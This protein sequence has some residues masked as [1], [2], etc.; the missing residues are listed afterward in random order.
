M[1]IGRLVIAVLLLLLLALAP[2]MA[3]TVVYTGQT[4]PLAVEQKN[5]DVYK[6]ELYNDGT[7]DFATEPGNC[8]ASLA[9][10]DPVGGNIGASVNVKWVEPGI[11]FFKVTALNASGCAMN[12]KIGIIEV[13]SSA[14]A[15]I[16]QPTGPVCAGEPV[17]LEIK[18]SGT[19]P[20]DF[21]YTA[22]DVDDVTTTH[23][24]ED[25]GTD[26]YT[27]TIV[28]GPI[29]TT[30]YTIIS[31]TDQNGTN[32]DPSNTVTQVVKALPVPVISGLAT[33][34]ANEEGV[35]Y[36]TPE[37]AGNTY[38]WIVT[39][40]TIT[41]GDETHEI[42]VTWDTPG[43]GTVEV[44]ET[45]AVTSCEKTV[46]ITVDVKQ[47]P[48]PVIAGKLTACEDE[49]NV[50]YST[51]E[52][53][54]NTYAWVVTGGTITAGDETHEITV[55]WD[56]PGNG[57][58]E[59]TETMAVTSCEKTV[60]ITVD[61]KQ[62]P[63]PVIA[64]KL[65]ACEDEENVVY[66]T[67]EVAGNTYAWVVTGGSITDGAGTHE[68]TVTW[69]TIGTGSVQVTETMAVTNCEKTVSITVPVNAIPTT[70]KILHD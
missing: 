4:T 19:G 53:A 29:T 63:A 1:Y 32:D 64:G 25:V 20:W 14:L 37:V 21:T 46:S 39:G 6:W 27:L 70:S 47:A 8:P 51:P 44:T 60:S 26:L 38:A 45:M 66:S 12:L 23:T 52:V 57:T 69:D 62:A 67:P 36:S 58:V 33:A 3:Q 9:D 61:V 13:K 17:L 59:V 42:T 55:T 11:Y 2:A 35:V 40:G 10:F 50:V 28:P 31:I 48:A 15:E 16:T 5:G 56:T 65:T 24:V 22:E 18:F 68:I 49:E 34:C 43:N 7:V 41:A 54:G 30:K